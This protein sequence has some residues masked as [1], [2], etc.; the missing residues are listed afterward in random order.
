L[1][2]APLYEAHRQG[3][4]EVSPVEEGETLAEG[5]RI[6]YPVRGKQILAAVKQTEGA[7]LAVDDERI[8]QAHHELAQRGFHVEFTSAAPVAALKK[9]HNTI[10]ADQV[11]VVPLTGSGFKSPQDDI[12]LNERNRQGRRARE[13]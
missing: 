2:C 9:L 3:A 4:D 10:A 1:G 13:L 6:P 12:Y 8:A 5:I 11:T 7:I